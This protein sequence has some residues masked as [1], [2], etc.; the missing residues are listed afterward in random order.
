MSGRP[1]ASAMVLV[2]LLATACST[3]PSA[4]PLADHQPT[5]TSSPAT[6]VAITAA[7]TTRLTGGEPIAVTLTGFPAHVTVSVSECASAPAPEVA[8]CAGASQVVYTTAKGGARTTFLAQ[9]SA[10]QPAGH[11]RVTCADQCV[12]LAGVIKPPP[13]A[14]NQQTAT[15]PLSF[16]AAGT[17][18]LA[19]ASLLDLTWVSA[20][21]GWALAGQPCEQGICA[22]IA[23]TTDSG[24]HWHLLPSPPARVQDE[25]QG[26]ATS[27]VS[28]I[29]FANA[30][31]G[32][33]FG[34]ALLM[35]TDGGRSWQPMADKQV[36]TLEVVHGTVLR[37]AYTRS[38]CPGPCDVS[39]ES[40]AV[41]STTW[42][43]LVDDVEAPARSSTSGI[44]SSG[45]AV[46]VAMFGS[47]A[48]P[49]PATATIYRS[50]DGGRSWRQRA[51]P[52][53]PQHGDEYDLVD[54]AGAPS[55]F[56]VGLC[57]AHVSRGASY[58]VTSTDGGGTWQKAGDVPADDAGLRRHRHGAVRSGCG[59]VCP[60][61]V[62][63]DRS[64]QRIWHLRRGSLRLHRRRRALA[65]GGARSPAGARHRPRVAGLRDGGRRALGR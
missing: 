19:D 62:R 15:V 65:L 6:R 39:L 26:C 51:D 48:G 14:G 53:Q 35:T 5:A 3:S 47:Q 56:F 8:S 49:V 25:D 59:D 57:T 61:T 33:L 27:C 9:P 40:A 32:Y 12:L 36:E 30:D 4:P 63:R 1:A 7:P 45:S 50:A 54:L 41:G 55:G 37:T 20:D 21:V 18:D 17:P 43:P 52:C 13:S 24:R 29:R 46:L 44:A 23:R 16:G 2:G 64:D 34:P 22:R 38:G 58:V 11:G 31:V 28:H 42:R 60:P 10:V